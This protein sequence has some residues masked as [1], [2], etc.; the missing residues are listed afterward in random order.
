MELK[1]NLHA[2]FADTIKRLQALVGKGITINNKQYLVD[3]VSAAKG[4]ESM[5]LFHKGKKLLIT[6][7]EIYCRYTVVNDVLHYIQ[8][9]NKG[10]NGS[11][12]LH[13]AE[14]K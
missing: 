10:I 4:S 12:M 13:N 14:V 3:S 2:A 5:V 7:N 1:H 8:H 11:I 9:T 6:S